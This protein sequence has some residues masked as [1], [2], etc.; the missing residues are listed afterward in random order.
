MTNEQPDYKQSFG[1]LVREIRGDVTQEGFAKRIGKSRPHISNVER[2]GEKPSQDLLERLI[3]RYP[4]RADELRSAYQRVLHSE[5]QAGSRSRRG[6]AEE[7]DPDYEMFFRRSGINDGLVGEWFARWQ[8]SVG[9]SQNLNEEALVF[10]W[11]RQ[12]LYI[13]NRE[14]SADNPKGGYL[15]KAQCR[16]YDN[17]IVTGTYTAVDPKIRFKGTLYLVLHGSGQHFTGHWVGFSYDYKWAHGLVAISRDRD[18]LPELLQSHI[19]AFPRMPYWPRPD[20]AI[21]KGSGTKSEEETSKQ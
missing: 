5:H 12:Y 11:R 17:E 19:N 18:E 20:E 16:F 9:A 15:W 3:E 14:A 8:T 10:S 4:E 6:R 21:A 13:E 7:E 1:D 2:G